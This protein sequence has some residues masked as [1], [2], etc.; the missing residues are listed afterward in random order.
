M[1]QMMQGGEMPEEGDGP[2]M[3]PEQAMAILQQFKI[4]M[5]AIPQV[6]A[7]CEAIE[8]AGQGQMDQQ[9]PQQMPGQQSPDRA[10]LIQALA[11]R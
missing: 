3:P 6:L 9:Q 4:P 1:D 5:E 2:T 7:A 10:S 11:S 8:Y